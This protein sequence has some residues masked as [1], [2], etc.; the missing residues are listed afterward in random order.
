MANR[1]IEISTSGR[2]LSAFRGF[3]KISESG[4]EVARVALDDI[5]AVIIAAHGI[6]FSNDL[7]VRLASKNIWLVSCGKNYQPASWLWPAD[8][9]SLEAQRIDFQIALP[10]ATKRQIWAD[11]VRS[12]IRGQIEVLAALDKSTK[13]LDR[14]LKE[15]R[16]GDGDNREAVA[17]Q[18]YW[19]SLFGTDFRRNRELP[20]TNAALNF[21]YTILR[22]CVCRAIAGSGLHP[23][24]P[25]HHS[26]KYSSFR[27]ADDLME[28]FRPLVDFQVVCVRDSVESEGLTPAIKKTLAGIVEKEILID[29]S[30][31]QLVEATTRIAHSLVAVTTSEVKRL[32]LPTSLCIHSVVE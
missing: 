6:T 31:Y 16:S 3:L 12:K 5:C 17:A 23:N 1:I 4:Q 32:R 29:D 27:L 22:S 8:S 9:H 28:V 10:K 19:P 18:V 20:G 2:H 13:R 11:I 24:I 30:R 25:L 26:N 21:G 14:L 15:V 7:I